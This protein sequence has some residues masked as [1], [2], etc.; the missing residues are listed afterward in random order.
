MEDNGCG[1]SGFSKPNRESLWL[2]V[3]TQVLCEALLVGGVLLVVAPASV[4]MFEE[5][6]YMHKE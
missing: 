1:D 6:L 4:L 3:D 5:L 2:G